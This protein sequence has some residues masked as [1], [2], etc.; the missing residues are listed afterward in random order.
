MTPQL[1]LAQDERRRHKRLPWRARLMAMSFLEGNQRRLAPLETF[2]ISYSGLGAIS[3]QPCTHGQEMVVALPRENGE[4]SYVP[5][6]VV[7]CQ[8][9]PDGCHLGLVFASTTSPG[10]P[11]GYAA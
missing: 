10:N 9:R 11:R 1:T 4:C 6:K 8:S 5:A 2:D 7:R 3:A